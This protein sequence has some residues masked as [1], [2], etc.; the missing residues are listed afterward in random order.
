MRAPRRGSLTRPPARLAP[1]ALLALLVACASPAPQALPPAGQLVVYFDTD[2]PVPAAPGQTLPP[3]APP[4]LFDRLLVDVFRPGESEPCAG[5]SRDFALDVDSLR[6]ARVSVGVLE[7]VGTPGYRVRA[8]MFRSAASLD[9]SPV[10][11]ATVEVV[12][13]LPAVSSEGIVETT[14]MLPTDS[15]GSPS[16]TLDAPVAAQPGPPAGS[17]VGTWPKA[18]TDDCAGGPR[19]DEVCI[20]GGAY[21][22]GNARLRGVADRPLLVVVSP[23][24]LQKTEVT[25]AAYRAS[26][27]GGAL[28][29][30]QGANLGL[31]DACTFT[32]Q[33]ADREALPLTCV[34]WPAARAYCQRRGGDLPT[35]AQ[36]EF[37]AGGRQ[38]SLYVWG[39]SNPACS[40]AVFGHPGPIGPVLGEALPCPPTLDVPLPVG[41]AA[42]ASRTHDALTVAG[43]GTVYDLAGNAAEWTRDLWSYKDD[44]HPQDTCWSAVG[45]LVD[46]LC[47]QTTE[48]ANEH[49]VRGGAYDRSGQHAAA[50]ARSFLGDDAGLV[51]SDLGFRCARRGR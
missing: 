27:M 10:A 35:E 19:D 1:R 14:V 39:D 15:V 48:G 51:G 18:Q 21:W 41:D 5:C 4:P 17:A 43:Q 24:F 7:A 50:A 42:P 32:D 40:W 28:T 49:V 45:A 34:S 46:P 44:A 47:T 25:V 9:G 3:G 2:A 33:P 12:A 38:G 26:G 20:Q 30:S 37:A 13:A 36:F 6:A 16:G 8:R 22:M 29:E 11:R 23:F 31:G